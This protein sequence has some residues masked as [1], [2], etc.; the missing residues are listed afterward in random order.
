MKTPVYL[1]HPAARWRLT[2]H[3]DGRDPLVLARVL[4]KTT[5]PEIALETAV[6]SRDPARLELTV[7]CSEARAELTC[8]KLE[9]LFDVRCASLQPAS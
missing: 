8:Q 1:P 7:T 3:A 2:V 5:M 9:R 6:Y 4:Q